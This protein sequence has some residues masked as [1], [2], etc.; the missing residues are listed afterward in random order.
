MTEPIEI[1]DTAEQV[2]PGIWHWQIANSGIGG[3]VSSCQLYASDEGGILVDPVH[4]ADEAMAQLPRPAAI[5]L[6]S[7]G[8]Q[9]SAWRYRRQF[10][11]PVW[12]PAGTPPPDE[13]PDHLY[14]DGDRLPGGFR[15]L[16]TPGPA[17]VHFCLLRTGDPG[18]LACSDLLTGDPVS[19]LRFV[20]LEF[21]DDPP[22]TRQSVE[23]LLELPFSLLCLDHG[24]P[25]S[26]GKAAIRELLAATA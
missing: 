9:R 18:V 3:A 5:L 17:L 8:H 10:G 26:D 11:A 22:A 14:G 13:R 4:L 7:K 25:F 19:G 12:A 16:Q 20:P 21:H 2:V 15:V 1:A 24:R 6:T 23:Q